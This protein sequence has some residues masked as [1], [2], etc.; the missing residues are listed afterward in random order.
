[1]KISQFILTVIAVA[2]ILIS[3]P[4]SAQSFFKTDPG[5]IKI[6]GDTTYGTTA[7]VTFMPGQKTKTHT[8]SAHFVYALTAGTL[9]IHYT[10]GKTEEFS[11]K[12]GDSFMAPAE[13]PHWT[14]NKGKEPI[15]FVLVEFN[16]HP[17]KD[18]KMK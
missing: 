18:K 15:R 4:V 5:M 7:E 17:Y 11:M 3:Q 14:E 10:D 2:V 9:T 16:E 12:A 1:M 6:L 13:K 8:H